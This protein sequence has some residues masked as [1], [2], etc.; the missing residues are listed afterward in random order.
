M[1][2]EDYLKTAPFQVSAA[3]IA[4]ATS[5]DFPLPAEQGNCTPKE[6]AAGGPVNTAATPAAQRCVDRRKFSFRLRHH[7]HQR[8]V[9]AKAYV[10]KRL[11]VSKRGHNLR[12]ITLK[13]LPLGKFKVKIVTRTN[14]HRVTRTTRT[15]K[16]CRKSRPRGSHSHG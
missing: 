10:N 15:Y 16:G 5:N 13:K 3:T 7:R 4:G 6:I 9:R 11:V 12:R 2:L 8:V 1:K 14:D